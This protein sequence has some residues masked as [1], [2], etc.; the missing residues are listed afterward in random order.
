ML[1][2][3][4]NVREQMRWARQ[5]LY[6]LLILTPLVLGISFV[7]VSR[8]ATEAPP[9]QPSFLA[10]L[11]LCVGF[12]FSL[13]GL[14]LTRATTEI[15]HVRKPEYMLDSLPVTLSTQLHAACLK[16]I[17]HTIVV[18]T[19]VVIV[20]S[21]SGAGRLIDVSV[22][23]PL[24]LFVSITSLTEVLSA[25]AW[26]HCGHGG[27]RNSA[28]VLIVAISVSALFAGLLLELIVRPLIVPGWITRLLLVS[29]GAGAIALYFLTRMLHQSWRASDIEYAKRLQDGGS[30]YEIF[31]RVLKRKFAPSIV[32]QLSRD[33]QL[34]LRAFSSAV[35]VALFMSMLFLLV[36]ITVFATGWLPYSAIV[37]GWFDA[38]WLPS[39]VAAKITCVLT[40][41]S[42]SILVAVLVAY[43]LPHFW[44]ERATGA[45]GTEMWETKLLYARAVSFSSPVVVWLISILSG[46]VPLFYMVPLLL[47]C[48]WLW[49]IVSTLIGALAFEMPDRPE[50]AIVL[51][52]SFGAVFGLLVASFWPIGLAF[53]AVNGYRG[54]ALRGHARA[55]FCL[56]TEGD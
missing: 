20:R 31:P 1:I 27:K 32:A 50:L 9:W 44:L 37:P 53:F 8:L 42:C 29:G 12:T 16:R 39:V 18:A 38:T 49:W 5:H 25:L 10:V 52:I 15:Y 7:T 47:E 51:M 6:T 46:T 33:L 41:A 55:R 24:I 43:Q 11:V 19:L 45:T 34:T 22:L 23:L 56:V 35:Y 48:L 21:L 36:L 30:R 40:T 28:L 17:S 13:I 54:L 4:A 2:V 26:I 14:S 3:G